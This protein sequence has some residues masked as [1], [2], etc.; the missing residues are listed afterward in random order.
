MTH[1]LGVYVP[2]RALFLVYHIYVKSH[3]SNDVA[4]LIN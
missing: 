4:D 3:F 1:Q 2:L